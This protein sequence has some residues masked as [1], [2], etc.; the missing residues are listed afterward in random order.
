MWCVWCFVAQVQ[1]GIL[2]LC[3]ILRSTLWGILS[4]FW[5]NVYICSGLQAY[6]KL[7][8]ALML[9]CNHKYIYENCS[10]YTLLICTFLFE[11]RLCNTLFTA[12]IVF[13]TTDSTLFVVPGQ[14]HFCPVKSTPTRFFSTPCSLNPPVVLSTSWVKESDSGWFLSLWALFCGFTVS[15]LHGINNPRVCFCLFQTPTPTQK[16]T[17]I[18]NLCFT[19]TLGV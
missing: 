12:D 14:G 5:P 7:L 11:M 3:T 1:F 2:M 4:T 13:S 18:I 19:R 16:Q 8:Q 9:S 6:N 10:F 17:T 15:P